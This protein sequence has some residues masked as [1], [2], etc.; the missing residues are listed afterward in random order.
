MRQGDRPE[1]WCRVKHVDPSTL[2]AGDLG[3]VAL[4]DQVGGVP[5]GAV[6]RLCLGALLHLHRHHG[7]MAQV[8]DGDVAILNVV[9]IFH[10][11]H[12]DLSVTATTRL[13]SYKPGETNK[14]S[15]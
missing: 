10:K 12:V 4:P 2:A 8:D 3:P 13:A 5:N 15:S 6:A 11:T 9:Q 1:L 7:V 14:R